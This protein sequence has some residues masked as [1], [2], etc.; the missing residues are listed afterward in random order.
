MALCWEDK[1]VAVVIDDDVFSEPFEGPSD[2]T[3]F[4]ITSDDLCDYGSFNSTMKALHEALGDVEEGE[5]EDYPPDLFEM[6]REQVE[7]L[8]RDSEWALQRLFPYDSPA[9]DGELPPSSLVL[10]HD[11]SS[12]ATPEF[13]FLQYASHAF[14]P[15]VV[16]FG[17]EL[18]SFYTTRHDEH[19]GDY[20]MLEEPYCTREGLRAY[21]RD[22]R[23][24]PGYEQAM[25]A[26][27]FV[28]EGALSPMDSY[29]IECL[30]LPRELGGYELTE[31]ATGGFFGDGSGA[32]GRAPTADSPYTAYDLCWPWQQV[33]LQYTGDNPPSRRERRSLAAPQ[34]F[35]LDVVCVT[36][37]EVKDPRAFEEAALLL[38]S[39][40]DVS[41]PNPNAAFAKARERLRQ[42]LTF[43]DYGHM[44]LTHLNEHVRET[45]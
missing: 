1:K 7:S 40:L 42:Q 38:A 36:T 24:Y 43:P 5:F 22:A 8:R 30:C 28:V 45:L 23:G 4:H 34:T 19:Q 29:L 31:P 20:I 39:K 25:Q 44:A 9:H 14:L 35:D 17:M 12:R 27:E 16:Q 33:A 26:L 15:Q 2:W 10:L 32:L 13:A 18:C 3:V 41:L 37:Q 11:G 21:L 6:A